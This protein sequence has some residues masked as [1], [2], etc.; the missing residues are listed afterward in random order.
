MRHEKGEDEVS[1]EIERRELAKN[2]N[3]IVW[4][5][6]AK[7][8]AMLLVLL[9]H[10]RGAFFNDEMQII[11][12]TL[13]NPTFFLASGVLLEY[14]SRKNGFSKFEHYFIK[15]VIPFGCFSIL[16]GFFGLIWNDS[17][18]ASII[19]AAERLWFFPTLFIALVFGE[20]VREAKISDK[21]MIVILFILSIAACFVSTMIA[22]ILFFTLILEWGKIRKQSKNSIQIMLFVCY[23]IFAYM[24]FSGM[25]LHEHQFTAAG[26]P[27]FGFLFAGLCGAEIIFWI[28]NKFYFLR[29]KTV[30]S[31]IG[32]NSLYFYIFHFIGI[33]IM[34]YNLKSIP[35]VVLGGVTT[36]VVPCVFIFV[37]DVFKG[38]K[39]N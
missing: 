22:K 26:M 3:R 31:W 16:Y 27:T 19:I 11:I 34:E 4:I 20:C 6:S 32:K 35:L 13:C 21:L 25:I 15:L 8:I 9:G 5:D 29:Q 1:Q 30:I 38:I 7:G 36:I 14:S 2:G 39:E 28:C 12:Y 17:L 10:I 37:K 18:L 23:F 33:Y 24:V